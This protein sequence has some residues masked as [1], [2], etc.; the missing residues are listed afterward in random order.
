VWLLEQQ[1][2][3]VDHQSYGEREEAHEFTSIEKPIAD[4]LADVRLER[5]ERG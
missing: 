5:G 1:P 3:R 2:L 4:F